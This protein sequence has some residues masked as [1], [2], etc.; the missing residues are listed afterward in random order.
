MAMVVFARLRYQAL[1]MR[2]SVLVEER[3]AHLD[4]TRSGSWARLG[5]ER[6]KAD[7]GLRS[8]R[9][10]PIFSGRGLMPL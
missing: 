7:A 4:Q 6:A 3:G 9:Q 8:T 10:T 5:D 1:E 2:E